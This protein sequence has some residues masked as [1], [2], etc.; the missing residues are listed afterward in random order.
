MFFLMKCCSVVADAVEKYFLFSEKINI[1]T[2]IP[3]TFI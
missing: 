2:V 1:I 3:L